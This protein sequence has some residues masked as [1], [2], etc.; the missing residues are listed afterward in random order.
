M[1][2]HESGPATTG[3][4]LSEEERSSAFA[5]AI[6]STR[7]DGHRVARL[8]V[9]P[10]FVLL[11]AVAFAVL[12]IGGAVLE[13]FYGASGVTTTT[14]LAP[15][16]TPPTG[17]QLQASTQAFIG[18]REIASAKAPD[19]TLRD[20]FDHRWSLR[21]ARGN[22]VVLTFMN[23]R[24]NDIC[25]VLGAEI[26]QAQHLLGRH[27]PHVDFVIVNTDA[28]HVLYRTHPLLLSLFGLDHATNVRFLTGTL[29]D[30]NTVWID[31]GLSVRVGALAN[32][33]AHNDVMYF[34]TRQGR[35]HSLAVPFANE[36][37]RG[38]FTLG[39]AD[40]HRFAEGISAVAISLVG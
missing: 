32:Q 1:T 5:Q 35:L 10:R 33:I 21:D 19:F 11:V 26:A 34:I 4:V 8:Q 22:V 40:I 30:L 16:P 25:P 24:C 12:G 28:H 15:T 3:N 36:D 23:A 14:V 7:P 9:P 39:A 27:Q 18:L 20:Q 2:D 6:A 31:Y 37:H 29:S 17:T 38:V 13:H